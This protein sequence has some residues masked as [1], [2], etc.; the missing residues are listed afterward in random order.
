MRIEKQITASESDY[1]NLISCLKK[2]E[3]L[4]GTMLDLA[5][6]FFR[7]DE[8]HNFSQFF[9]SVCEKIKTVQPLSEYER[10][11]MVDIINNRDFED[12]RKQRKSRGASYGHLTRRL[13]KNEP[14]KGK[15]LELALELTAVHGDDELSRLVRNMRVKM[16]A[17]QP[18][19]EYEYH[20]MVEVL[21]LH[22]RLGA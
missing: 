13:K 21:M 6:N 5:L 20:I 4:T 14:L 12:K 7:V 18:L 19:D 8:N 17:G 3:L 15:T 22:S 16:Q 9:E 10:H 1:D 11:V 2:N